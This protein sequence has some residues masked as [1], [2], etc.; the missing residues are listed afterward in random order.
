ML[1]SYIGQRVMVTTPEVVFSGRVDA[2]S[3]TAVTLADTS[4]VTEPE[5][6]IPIDGRVIIPLPQILHVQVP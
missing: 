6:R 1:R 3:R 5:R 2:C 4:D